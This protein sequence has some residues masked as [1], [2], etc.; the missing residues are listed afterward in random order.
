MEAFDDQGVNYGTVTG[1]FDFGA[2]DLLELKGPGK[3]PVLIPF[4]ETSVLEIDLEA[5]KLLIDPLAAGLIDDP[6]DLKGLN[7]GKP[8]KKK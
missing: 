4:S 7:P 6:D 3:R 5:G 1:V 8:K 2:G